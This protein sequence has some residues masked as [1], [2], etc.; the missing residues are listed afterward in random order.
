MLTPRIRASSLGSASVWR[1]RMYKAD[2]ELA[3][4]FAQQHRAV[5][6]LKGD[7][8]IVADGTQTFVGS[9]GN[10]GMATGDTQADALAGVGAVHA[11]S[12]FSSL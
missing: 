12:G 2:V 7:A 5:V 9:T 10:P 11:R 6:V 3:E 8:A 1:S 4:S